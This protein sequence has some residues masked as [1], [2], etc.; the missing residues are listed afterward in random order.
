MQQPDAVGKLGTVTRLYGQP[1]AHLYR[2]GDATEESHETRQWWCSYLTN[3]TLKLSRHGFGT[4][5]EP[6]TSSPA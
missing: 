5:A 2:A 3:F 4:A 1:P 6:P